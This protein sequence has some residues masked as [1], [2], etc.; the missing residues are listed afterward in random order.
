MSLR[1]RLTLGLVVLAAVGSRSPGSRPSARCVRSCSTA[2][3][4]NSTD[5]LRRPA[6]SARARRCC[7]PAAT[8]RS[9]TRNGARRAPTTTRSSST[10]PPPDLP[11]RR[12]RSARS[13]STRRRRPAVSA[14]RP[15]RIRERQHARDRAPARRRAADA[16]PAR[17]RRARRRWRSCSARWLRSAGGSSGS[18]CARCERM[19]ETADAIAAGRPARSA[20]SPRPR[21][22]KSGG[23]GSRSTACSVR[24]RARSPSETRP[25]RACGSSS[26]DASHELRTPLTSIRGYAELFRP[27]ADQ[28]PED[29]A[30]AMRRIEEEA[31]RM[32]VLVDDLLLLARLDQ[33]RPLEREPVDLVPYSRATPST[34]RAPRTRGARSRCRAN[35]AVTVVGDEQRLRQVLANLLANAFT[36]TPDGTP[37]QRRRDASTSARRAS[38]RWPTTGPASPTTKPRTCSSSSGAPT[39]PAT[40]ARGGAGL[41][42]SIVQAIAV[43]HGG[44]AE[45]ETGPGPRRDVPGPAPAHARARCP[46]VDLRTTS[47]PRWSPPKRRTSASGARSMPSR[48][49]S[50]CLMLPSATHAAS[51]AAPAA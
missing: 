42:L 3:T 46:S 11:E 5:A 41:G 48:T 18:G 13:R 40:A 49:C 16:A 36:H 8:T 32:G 27:G 38:S 31:A 12:C 29:L 7:R 47:L 45:V 44:T 2:S 22:P 17:V 6:L 51:C 4:S 14:L 26:A 19:S 15:E 30:K 1:A 33:G 24:S 37:V 10:R 25:R 39:R 35:G 50:R 28:R 23:S 43:A 34:T 21:R 20:S 9:A